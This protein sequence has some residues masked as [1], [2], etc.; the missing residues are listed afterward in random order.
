MKASITFVLNIIKGIVIVAWNGIKTTI[1]VILT[2]I[3]TVVTNAWNAIKTVVS[4][5]GLSLIHI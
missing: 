1:S 4:V 3:K 2:T 5:V